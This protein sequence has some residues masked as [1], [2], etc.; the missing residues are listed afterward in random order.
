M[1]KRI[2]I[3]SSSVPNILAHPFEEL[4]W[5]VPDSRASH[6]LNPGPD[7]GCPKNFL[8]HSSSG[9]SPATEYERNQE[10]YEKDEE[11]HPRNRFGC[12]GDPSES[13]SAR[14]QRDN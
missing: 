14:N 1:S 11:K 7:S 12:P 13:E 4:C 2:K 10:Q 5:F 3:I 8:R 6:D 9:R